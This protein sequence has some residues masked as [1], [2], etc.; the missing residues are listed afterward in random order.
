MTEITV[1]YETTMAMTPG[2]IVT[3]YR[4]A[5]NRMKQ[6]SILADQNLCI[7]RKHS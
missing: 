3:E 6:I 1:P 4:Q 2:E 5:K 7:P